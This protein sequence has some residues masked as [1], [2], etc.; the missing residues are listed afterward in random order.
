MHYQAD[1]MAPVRLSRQPWRRL[2]ALRMT[3]TSWVASGFRNVASAGYLPSDT[4]DER[5]R[6]NIFMLGSCIGILAA[7]LWGAAYFA[8]GLR[9]GSLAFFAYTLASLAIVAF[10]LRTKRFAAALFLQLLLVLCLP[11]VTQWAL[12]GIGNS[13]GFMIWALF[14]PLGALLVQGARRSLRWL[15]AFILLALISVIV[16]PHVAQRV[17][18]VP[19]AAVVLFASLNAVAVSSLIYGL[20]R[21]FV[22]E[23]ERVI[24]SLA[25]TNQ[26]LQ[27]EEERA[28]RLLLN[29]LPAPIAERLKSAPHV[30]ADAFPDVT[31]LFADIVG[32]TPLSTLLSPAD[33]VNLLNRLFSTFDELADHYGL[34]KIKTIG[35]AY[36][37][38]GGLPL[39][40]PDHAEA[41][42]DMALAMRQAIAPFVS[43][44]GDPFSIRIG[45][46]TGPVVAGVIGI[47][48][49]S[50]DLWGDTVNIASR[51]ESQGLAGRIQV[52]SATYERLRD[53]Y[54]F[55][56]RGVI[57]VK[58]KGPV[59]T[60]FLLGRKEPAV[61]G[62]PQPPAE[63][64]DP[65]DERR[66]HPQPRP[67][68][69]GGHD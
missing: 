38:V 14:A 31:V 69:G 53:A 68:A 66:H 54:C 6:K 4:D 3:L 43:E 48:K 21:Y 40:R 59:R 57:Y 39:P 58:G 47:K 9:A 22:Q 29:I 35:D 33:I 34:E 20:V 63:A 42:A 64:P 17:D 7:T 60:Y 55:E 19:E 15:V 36:M 28:E 27:A 16:E 25:E 26:R 18:A 10:F 44:I 61:S 8:L 13:S 30:I 1:G 46:N 51:M 12:G 24:S 50:Y 62:H 32:F 5:L 11:F 2:N 45:I 52:T 49:F 41:V 23:R 65:A 56:E 67:Q 37:A